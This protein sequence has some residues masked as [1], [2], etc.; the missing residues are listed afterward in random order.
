MQS[1]DTVAVKCCCQPKY[2]QACAVKPVMQ[3]VCAF[4]G[5]PR[6]H[7][8]LTSDQCFTA[9]TVQ[10]RH[11]L[12]RGCN[13]M[14]SCKRHLMQWDAAQASHTPAHHPHSLFRRFHAAPLPASLRTTRGP[15]CAP[16]TTCLR[17]PVGTA[18][19]T[20]YVSF[21]TMHVE[22]NDDASMA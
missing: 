8:P 15:H 3:D 6:F 21:C 16:S 4:A 5:P 7:Q 19:S 18:A 17:S 11:V 12:F 22:D 14:Y 1:Q 20:L 13:V 9:C 2:H 10:L